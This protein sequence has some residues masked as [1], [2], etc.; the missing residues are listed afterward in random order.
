MADTI[1]TAASSQNFRLESEFLTKPGYKPD[2]LSC[3]QVHSRQA[4]IQDNNHDQPKI[5]ATP[6]LSR[7]QF[8]PV[9]T[10]TG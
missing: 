6:V 3:H 4:K 1:A 5:T 8:L 10:N 2:I 7:Q 9:A